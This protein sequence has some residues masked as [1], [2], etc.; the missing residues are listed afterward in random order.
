MQPPDFHPVPALRS[1]DTSLPPTLRDIE[2]RMP[3]GHPYRHGDLATWAHETTHGLNAR[4]RNEYRAKH[5][6]PKINA[7]YCL[8]GRAVI[9]PE[10]D[11]TIRRV[12]EVVPPMFRGRLYQNYL[13]S[14]Q[15]WWN[16]RP[17]YL[18]D[19]WLSYFHD[20]LVS[21]EI[22]RTSHTGALEFS[23][24][25]LAVGQLAGFSNWQVWK[26]ILWQW[27][28]VQAVYA[29]T[30]NAMLLPEERDYRRHDLRPSDVEPG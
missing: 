1:V 7:F 28:R 16:D 2:S 5:G 24:Y 26:F 17:L 22:G 11:T 15:Q 21:K 13:V 19:E 8:D 30:K 3:A 12:S 9:L 23:A 20:A 6:Y 27:K 10:P 29:E 4:I 14:Q 25:M 18:G